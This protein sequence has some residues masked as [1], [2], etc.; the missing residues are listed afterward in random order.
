VM[1]RKVYSPRSL[2]RAFVSNP[3][4]L[5]VSVKSASA[6]TPP[7]ESVT[8]PPSVALPICAFAGIT[9]HNNE[10]SRHTP[11]Y[12][13]DRTELASIVFFTSQKKFRGSPSPHLAKGQPQTAQAQVKRLRNCAHYGTRLLQ[14]KAKIQNRNSAKGKKFMVTLRGTYSV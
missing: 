12:L 1:L 4:A 6:T 2:E 10:R 9:K 13:P 14:V 5:F 8:V 7:E 3:V 11:T